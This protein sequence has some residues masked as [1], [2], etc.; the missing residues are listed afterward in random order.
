MWIAFADS[1]EEVSIVCRGTNGVVF[2]PGA[3]PD[4][5]YCVEDCDGQQYVV[6]L[7]HLH[8][9][10]REASIESAQLAKRLGVE[11]TSNPSGPGDDPDDDDEP[12]SDPEPDSDDDPDEDEDE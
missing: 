2:K 9:T 4:Q 10:P 1:Y 6:G 3:K 5:P 8:H 7:A 12:D 11:R